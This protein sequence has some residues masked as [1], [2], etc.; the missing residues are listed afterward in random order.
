MGP[1]ASRKY[2][3]NLHLLRGEGAIVSCCQLCKLIREWNTR[4]YSND[5]VETSGKGWMDMELPGLV[6][7]DPP[8]QGTWN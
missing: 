5:P 1:I 6:E 2:L 3:H 4:S 8:Q 7:Y